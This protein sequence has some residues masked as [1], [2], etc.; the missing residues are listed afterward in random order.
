M[1]ATQS[2]GALSTKAGKSWSTL[3]WDPI[4]ASVFR[5]QVRIA[6]PST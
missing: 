6:A 3:N 1:T 2:T 4:K 5:L